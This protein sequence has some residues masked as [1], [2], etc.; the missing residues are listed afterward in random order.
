MQGRRFWKQSFKI[1]V[2]EESVNYFGIEMELMATTKDA[3]IDEY[4]GTYSN[5]FDE[6]FINENISL[7]DL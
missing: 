6:D 3:G 2:L 1:K 7:V 5:I 4:F